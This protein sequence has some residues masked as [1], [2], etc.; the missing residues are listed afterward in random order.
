MQ[1]ELRRVLVLPC[2]ERPLFDARRARPEGLVE[3]VPPSSRDKTRFLTAAAP[4]SLPGC[5][6]LTH[7]LMALV[8]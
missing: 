2:V 5:G 8:P 1:R 3:V 6:L 4:G 7:I